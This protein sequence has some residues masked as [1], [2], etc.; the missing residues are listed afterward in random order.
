MRR[1]TIGCKS[2]S[3]II[4]RC[5]ESKISSPTRAA[6]QSTDP[7]NVNGS[8]VDDHP[9]VQP[10]PNRLGADLL[11]GLAEHHHVAGLVAH[12]GQRVVRR[13]GGGVGVHQVAQQRLIEDVLEPDARRQR[14]DE[15]LAWTARS[16]AS[17]VMASHIGVPYSDT[18]LGGRKNL[19]G[20][21]G[22]SQ[23]MST[24]GS[25][26]FLTEPRSRRSENSS[27]VGGARGLG[28]LGGKRS[29]LTSLRC[30]RSRELRQNAPICF[31][32]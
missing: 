31:A 8:R 21:S 5:S 11:D 4:C 19:S 1:C 6:I 10:R 17:R 9:L 12:L 27:R 28:C 24:M 18:V 14:V 3:S 13:V 30:K 29:S 15:F 7:L 16:A 2:G 32:T 20:S 25:Y 26:D 23:S 22:A